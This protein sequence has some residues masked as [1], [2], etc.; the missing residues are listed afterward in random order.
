[1]PYIKP[2]VLVINVSTIPGRVKVIVSNNLGQDSRIKYQKGGGA[3]VVHPTLVTGNTF[4]YID[5]LTLSSD[6]LF[7]AQPY[8][9]VNDVGDPSNIH[10]LTVANFQV[11]NKD[12]RKHM[13]SFIKHLMRS[14]QLFDW[15]AKKI[16]NLEG[17]PS[18]QLN[19]PF[20]GTLVHPQ[21]NENVRV[22][23]Q[24]DIFQARGS[25]PLVKQRTSGFNKSQ[26]GIG[27]VKFGDFTAFCAIDYEVDI[28]DR[29]IDP[30][31]NMEYKVVHSTPHLNGL[32]RHLELKWLR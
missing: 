30:V 4:I 5:N 21:Y 24:P 10:E 3:V 18:A 14:T 19:I 6:Y 15:Y 31:N 17:I 28:D 7:F 12:E 16:S 32:Y 8:D 2:V 1:M 9:G 26:I 11:K 23:D 29:I 13:T 22:A 20:S 25:I 27:T